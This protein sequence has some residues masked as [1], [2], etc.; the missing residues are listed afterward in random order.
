MMAE[1]GPTT[2]VGA[3][4]SVEGKEDIPSGGPE[5]RR[6][7]A[8]GL[9]LPLLGL[10]L[11]SFFLPTISVCEGSGVTELRGYDL[12]W[13]GYPLYL[14]ALILL[15]STVG[16]LVRRHRPGRVFGGAA[17]AALV[18][19]LG[20]WF[21]VSWVTLG[22]P[23]K[24]LDKVDWGR[25]GF[26]L[27]YL[28]TTGIMACLL[29]VRGIATVGGWHRWSYFL[30]AYGCLAASWVL[31]TIIGVGSIGGLLIGWDMFGAAVLI[32]LFIVPCA[33]WLG[34]D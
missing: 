25:E 18:L 8:A 16:A 9:S 21:W 6:R 28:L 26:V 2:G 20:T 27:T 24:D 31:F 10:I 14:A 22:V 1:T 19:S 13:Q 17:S 29:L 7:W 30:G 23:L 33:S 15:L 3:S 11:A 34:K 4:T 32:L 12:D 5:V